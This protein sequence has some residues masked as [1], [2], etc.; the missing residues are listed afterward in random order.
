MAHDIRIV[1][2]AELRAAVPLD[3]T[4]VDVVERAFVALAGGDVVMP[5]I[6]S[7]EL[8]G[9]QG[10]VDAKTAY[11]PGFSL[12][13][14]LLMA[15]PVLIYAG[16]VKLTVRLAKTEN[17]GYSKAFVAFAYSV[18][19]IALFYHLAHNLE[20][21]LMEGQKVVP[22]LSNPFGATTTGPTQ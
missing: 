20:H 15:G 2:E 17:V 7:M 5:P 11:I 18:L 6:M 13:M 19:P 12:G 3:L 9:F 21:L 22:L 8:A 4:S 16:L 10:E 14:L 1:T